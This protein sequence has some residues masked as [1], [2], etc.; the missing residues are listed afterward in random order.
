MSLIPEKKSAENGFKKLA[1]IVVFVLGCICLCWFL[2]HIIYCGVMGVDYDFMSIEST[3]RLVLG[4]L[5]VT[6]GYAMDKFIDW[7]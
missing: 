5:M 2:F 4:F 7:E 6:A 3:G 1:S